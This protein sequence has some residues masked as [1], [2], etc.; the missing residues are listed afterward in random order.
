MLYIINTVVHREHVACSLR[1]VLYCINIEF[2][3]M[4]IS[5]ASTPIDIIYK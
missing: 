1:P 2:G 4:N 3:G 5:I